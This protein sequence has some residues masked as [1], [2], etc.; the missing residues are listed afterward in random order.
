MV[1]EPISGDWAYHEMDISMFATE[2]CNVKACIV[3]NMSTVWW[4]ISEYHR[5]QMEYVNDFDKRTL[6][7][8]YKVSSNNISN[9]QCYLIKKKTFTSKQP[10]QI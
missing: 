6:S 9:N 5:Q 1:C 8:S 3:D 2:S 7:S 10:V 4:Q